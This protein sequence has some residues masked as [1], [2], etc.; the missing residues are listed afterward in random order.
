MSRRFSGATLVLASHNPKK[1]DELRALMA[2]SEVE[3]RSAGELGLEEPDEPAPDFAG[4]ARIK[5]LAAATASGLPA[6]A[7]DSGLAVHGLDGA[8][9]VHS[10]RW[11]GPG[12]DYAAAMQRVTDGLALRFGSFA[13][14]DKRAAFLT[15]VCLAWPDGETVTVEGRIDGAIIEQPRGNAGFGYD[16]IFVPEGESRSFAELT[17]EEKAAISH[18]GRAMRAI[19][20]AC[21]TAG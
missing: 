12:K 16:P 19:L 7:D 13:A 5:A 17:A 9:G 4:N 8:P 15:V 18:R 20:R 14:A 3:V 1:L 6:L 11:A 10:A 2:P 21:F